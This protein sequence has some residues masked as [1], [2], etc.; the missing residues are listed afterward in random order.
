MMVEMVFQK[1]KNFDALSFLYFLT[2]SSAKLNKMLKIAGR[3]NDVMSRYHNALLCG[4]V[5]ERVKVLAECGQVSPIGASVYT[6]RNSTCKLCGNP[7]SHF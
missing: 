3:R 1:T 5:E 2:G 4:D 7:G 6:V